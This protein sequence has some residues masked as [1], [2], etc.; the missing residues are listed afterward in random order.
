MR[1][2]V[3]EFSF[4]F[5]D[6]LSVGSNH[7]N[8]YMIHLSAF[9]EEIRESG[10]TLNIKECSFARPEVKFIG[11]VIGSGHRHPYESK[12]ATISDLSRPVTK[13]DV[14]RMLGFF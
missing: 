2:S 3:K 11:N 4:S 10:L 7:W 6:D 12:F 8:H 9:L 13:R 5:V 14:K 1:Q